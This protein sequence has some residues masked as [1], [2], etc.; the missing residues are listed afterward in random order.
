MR[1]F[2]KKD[3]LLYVNVPAA[4]LSVRVTDP[5]CDVVVLVTCGGSFVVV[6]AIAVTVAVGKH[7]YINLLTVPL[8][9]NQVKKLTLTSWST[10]RV[11]WILRLV[12][13]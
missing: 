8:A 2:S 5:G 11:P 4:A 10:L 7:G 3:S 9:A 1:P 12:P 13:S 6:V